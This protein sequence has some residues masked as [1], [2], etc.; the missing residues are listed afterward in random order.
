M[1][2]QPP[3]RAILFYQ[4]CDIMHTE[5][6]TPQERTYRERRI[7]RPRNAEHAANMERQDRK[8]HLELLKKYRLRRLE[9][10]L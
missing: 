9:M 1:V 2:S 7:I 8:I 10:P 5:I 6:I 4:N 3:N